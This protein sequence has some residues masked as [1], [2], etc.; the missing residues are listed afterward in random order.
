MKT[1]RNVSDLRV[2]MHRNE[3]PIYFISATNFNLL[4]IDQ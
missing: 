3:R 1:I 2:V 4:G